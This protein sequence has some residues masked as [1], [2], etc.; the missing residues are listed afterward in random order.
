MDLNVI[1]IYLYSYVFREI[2]DVAEAYS[3]LYHPLQAPVEISVVSFFDILP[4]SPYETSAMSA[5]NSERK[6]DSRHL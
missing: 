1:Y 5:E 4:I 3:S 2:N 6:F